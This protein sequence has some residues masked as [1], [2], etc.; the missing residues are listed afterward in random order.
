VAGPS[1]LEAI[2]TI[3][4]GAPAWLARNGALIVEIAPDQA[5]RVLEIA[6]ESGFSAM[7]VEEDLA[8]RERVLVA[9]R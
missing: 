1:G 3:V 7:R 8:G 9:E 4:A 5:T 6:R 2:E